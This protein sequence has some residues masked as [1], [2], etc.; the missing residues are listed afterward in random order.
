LHKVQATFVRRAGAVADQIV[1]VAKEHKTDLLIMGGYGFNPVLQIA[2][3]ST[4]DKVL[5]EGRQPILIC[6]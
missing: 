6:R 3:G 2:L 4:V 1:A 5:R